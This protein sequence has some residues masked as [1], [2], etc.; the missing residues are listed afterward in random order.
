MQ[1]LQLLGAERLDARAFDPSLGA[2]LKYPE[3]IDDARAGAAEIVAAAR[4]RA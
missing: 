4:E 1:T 2:V 3:D